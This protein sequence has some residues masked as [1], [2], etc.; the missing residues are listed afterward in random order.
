MGNFRLLQQAR[1]EVIV[2]C[3]NCNLLE[4]EWIITEI[5]TIEAHIDKKNKSIEA[6][7]NITDSY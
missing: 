2:N 5:R 7:Q 4:H 6:R 1:C 3:A